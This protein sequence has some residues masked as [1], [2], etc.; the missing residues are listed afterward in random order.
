M[1]QKRIV[2]LEREKY[3]RE[4][5]ERGEM[6]IARGGQKEGGWVYEEDRGNDRRGQAAKRNLVLLKLGGK[7]KE[8]G[9]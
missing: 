6:G 2:T 1:G 7:S 5:N 3:I 9:T 4:L 8:L